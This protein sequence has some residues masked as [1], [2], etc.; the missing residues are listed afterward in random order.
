MIGDSGITCEHFEFSSH[1]LTE[2]LKD[3]IDTSIILYMYMIFNGLSI[4]EL[5][6]KENYIVMVDCNYSFYV[7]L[8]NEQIIWKV[9]A[10]CQ[11]RNMQ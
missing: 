11:G 6:I 3:S 5:L 4:L 10:L 7:Q 2:P 8:Q 1:L 9:H